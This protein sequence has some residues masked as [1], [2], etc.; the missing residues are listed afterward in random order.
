[1][2]HDPLLPGSLKHTSD[3]WPYPKELFT[4][5]LVTGILLVEAVLL[6]THI[7]IDQ[8]FRSAVQKNCVTI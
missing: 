4:S 2:G 7:Y 1:V 6:G 8:E 3:L 5:A